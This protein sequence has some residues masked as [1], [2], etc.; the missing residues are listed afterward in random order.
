MQSWSVVCY[1][2]KCTIFTFTDKKQKNL[3]LVF[4]P[5]VKEKQ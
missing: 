2:I 3:F 4:K 1:N 5:F